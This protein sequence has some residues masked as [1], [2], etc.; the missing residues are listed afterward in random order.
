MKIVIDVDRLLA[1]GGITAEE[2]KRLNAL[3]V[4]ETGSLAFNILIGF[5]VI[6][7]AGGAVALLP[8]AA[9]AIA[10]GFP[11]A[12]V[13]MYLSK[14]H[15][16]DWGLL[17]SML[18]LVGTITT[19]G[20]IVIAAEGGFAGFLIV[21]LLCL[22]GAAAAKSSLLAALSVLSLFF[23][24]GAMTAYNH[25]TYTL[26]I[27][28]PAL[29]V[30]L[31]SAL[32]WGLYN[33]S[34]VLSQDDQRLAIIA[35]RAS[36]FLVNLG[37]WVGSIWGDS[38]QNHRDDWTFHGGEVLPDWLFAVGWAVGLILTGVWAAQRNRRWVVNLSAVFGSIHLYTQYFERLGASPE[39]IFIAGLVA[40]GIAFAIVR[41]NQAAVAGAAE[42]ARPP[43][44][45][46]DPV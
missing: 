23:T 2:Y 15:A 26:V 8:S 28:Q 1:E 37:F 39:S 35:A 6:A 38:L 3:A 12:A 44:P 41:Y 36:L 18:L 43:G 17:G 27:R 9:T 5:G 11:L 30:A 4:H 40:L 32:A 16:R 42:G 19:V 25:A 20:G 24:L 34:K 29:T 46:Y 45:M 10:L 13:G 7:T 21:T 22:V 14:A 31:F 33:L